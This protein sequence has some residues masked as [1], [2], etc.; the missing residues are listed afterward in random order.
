M[1]CPTGMLRKAKS[2]GISAFVTR[3]FFATLRM[4][5]WMVV[6]RAAASDSHLRGD[7]HLLLLLPLSNL[8]G[9][10]FGAMMG[11]F[12]SALFNSEESL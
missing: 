4:T 7:C 1:S 5:V 11:T 12:P 6:F 8:T 3:R 2:K 10:L 9:V